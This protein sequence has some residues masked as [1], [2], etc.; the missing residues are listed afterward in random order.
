MVLHYPPATLSADVYFGA[1][2]N[3]LSTEPVTKFPNGADR[4][5]LLATGSTLLFHYVAET[6][7]VTAATYK[8]AV[9]MQ[10]DTIHLVDME[11]YTGGSAF[12]AWGG[13]T[14]LTTG[15]NNNAA[16][17]TD[18]GGGVWRYEKNFAFPADTTSM[19]VRFFVA[20]SA[21][22]IE[23]IQAGEAIFAGDLT[24]TLV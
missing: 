4:V 19:Q 15:T 12:F 17:I 9:T 10:A 1:T 14:N 7:T 5:R 20:N 3:N 8:L 23:Y 24:L 2:K 6:F 13:Q 22:A 16:T 21:G 18:L 11:L